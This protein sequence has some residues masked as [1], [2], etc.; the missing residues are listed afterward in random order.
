MSETT[1]NSKP[2]EEYD[3]NVR[4]T[5]RGMIHLAAFITTSLSAI[6]FLVIMKY[7]ESFN[8][9]V[10]LYF[11]VQI[12]QFGLSALY[13]TYQGDGRVKHFFRKLD[14]LAIFFLIC[15]TQTAVV[16]ML[17]KRDESISS[18]SFLKMTWGLAVL[19]SV[20]LFLIGEL[21][22]HNIFDLVVYCGQGLSILL[23]RRIF[24][25]FYST[26]LAI[27]VSG[28]VFYITGAVVYGAESPNPYPRV[29]GFHEIFHVCTLLGNACFGLS[30]WKAYFTRI[31]SK[32]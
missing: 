18:D 4:T 7:T 20:K 8:G 17:P 5:F 15:G 26:D 21:D 22:V 10:M 9:Y 11:L 25:N 27:L 16:K 31:I 14:H 30:I 32:V 2:K 23:F 28:G 29:F 13:H 12:M 19:G 1:S 6:V 24:L 3:P